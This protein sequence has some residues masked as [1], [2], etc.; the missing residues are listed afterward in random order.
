[1]GEGL[2]DVLGSESAFDILAGEVERLGWDGVLYTF[3]PKP[4]YMNS[5]IQ[6]VFHYSKAFE[7]FVLHYLKNDY[8]NRDFILRLALEGREGPVDWWEEISKGSVSEKEKMVTTDAK[9]NFGIHHGLSIPSLS[10]SFAVAGI[11]V[12][13]MDEDFDHFKK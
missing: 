11:S 5:E 10:G 4:M 13:S 6:P 3:F 7:P 9:I 1:M 12:M 2:G 8:G